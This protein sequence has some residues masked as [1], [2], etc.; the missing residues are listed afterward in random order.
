MRFGEAP[1][2][3]CEV[4]LR[5]MTDSRRIDQHVQQKK[6]VGLSSFRPFTALIGC[7]S[8][9]CIQRSCLGIFGPHY[10][11][12]A[13]TCRGSSRSMFHIL[14]AQ[15]HSKLLQTVPASRMRMPGNS[16]RSSQTRNCIGYHTLVQSPSR[17]SYK[18]VRSMPRSL[19][20]KLLS[21][22]SSPPKV[23][24]LLW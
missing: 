4:M 11:L 3:V 12:G 19:L 21:L 24:V 20:S 14:L 17:S 13:S 1:L 2:Q 22:S 16:T 10:K 18:T 7:P 9:L 15:G 8:C 5:D 23:L 6:A